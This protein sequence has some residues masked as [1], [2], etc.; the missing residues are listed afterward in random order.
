MKIVCSGTWIYDG[1]VERP[2]DVV[3]LSFDWWYELAKADALLEEGETP[4]A[5]GP[6]GVLYYARFQRAGD[7]SAST[8]VDTP[9]HQTLV[10]AM[11]AAELKVASGVAW[12]I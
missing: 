6:D 4:L 9:G 2:V 8:W 3:A 1:T 7:T 11:E 12:R 10:A 5:L